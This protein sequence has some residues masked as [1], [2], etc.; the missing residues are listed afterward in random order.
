MLLIIFW[1]TLPGGIISE[2]RAVAYDRK[3]GRHKMK[4]QIYNFTGTSFISIIDGDVPVR[5]TDALRTRT[6]LM[7]QE[8]VI[9]DTV[10]SLVGFWLA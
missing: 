9:K 4:K 10:L 3:P 8:L 6:G 2:S 1:V 5:S 7:E